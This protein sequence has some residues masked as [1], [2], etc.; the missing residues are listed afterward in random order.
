MKHLVTGN[1]LTA[2]RSS[3]SIAFLVVVLLSTMIIMSTNF[4][5]LTNGFQMSQDKIDKINSN[6]NSKWK[7]TRY[8]KFET[9]E[10]KDFVKN[11]PQLDDSFANSPSSFTSRIGK[12]HVYHQENNDDIPLTFDVREKWPGC[13]FPANNIMSCSAVGTFTIVDSISDRFC[14][15]TGGKFKKLLSS[16]YMLECDRDRQGCQGAVESDIFSYLEGNGTTTEE[17]IPY[18]SGGGEVVD[19]CSTQCKDG[20]PLKRYKIKKGSV[21]SLDIITD[22]Q[23]DI[24]KYGSITAG[25][26]MYL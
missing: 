13:V 19:S 16:Q 8:E 26:K 17:C 24:M 3:S 9:Q 1:Q 5:I 25:F 22:M 20:S 11:I 14:I 7:A 15:A 12:R 23:R 21:G 10:W 6:P 4:V 18:S 2:R